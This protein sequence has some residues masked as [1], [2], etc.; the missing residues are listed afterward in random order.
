[1]NNRVKVKGEPIDIRT[2]GGVA[3]LPP[4]ETKRGAYS[5][6]G[7]GLNPMAELPVARVGWTRER[8]R[9]KVRAAVAGTCDFPPGVGPIRNPER[10]CLRIASVQGQNGSRALV[11][12]VSVMRDAG[13]TPDQIFAFVK[14]VWGPACCRPEWSEREIRYCIERQGPKG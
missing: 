7:A 10:Y 3:V 9:K 14:T 4:S 11:R 13:R 8:T 2:D 5:W 12:V 6:L 1:M